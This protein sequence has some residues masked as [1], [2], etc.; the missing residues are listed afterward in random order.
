MHQVLYLIFN[1]GYSCSKG[2]A[3]IRT[4]LCEDAAHLCFMLCSHPDF[5]T[6]TTRALMALM[7]FHAA[8]LDARIDDRGFI[9]LM[10]DQDRS[11]WD[12]RL[13]RRA[14]QFLDD[15]AEGTTISPYHLEAG[16]AFHH[17]IARSHDD[18]D[19]PAILVLYDKLIAIAPSPLYVLNRAIVVA[20]IDGPLAGI[21]RPRRGGRN[22][23]TQELSPLR[24]HA[25]RIPSPPG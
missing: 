18:T 5:S 24:R 13:I 11:K 8:R 12:H 9:L 16:I 19:W 7:L 14:E 21:L 6:P 23:V 4:D 15:S 3:A 10:K 20:E 2:E 25:G 17:C 1:E 22:Q